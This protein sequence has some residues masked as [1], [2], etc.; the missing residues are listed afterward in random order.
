[1]AIIIILLGLGVLMAAAEIFVPGGVLGT[2]GAIAIVISIVLAF[3]RQGTAFG[4]AWL[5]A[6][7]ALTLLSIFAAAR[8]VP[9]SPLGKKILLETDQAGISSSQ[10]GLSDLLGKTGTALTDLRPAG[11]AEIESEKVDVVTSG[12]HIGRG[13]KVEVYKVDGNRV[14]VR[15]VADDNQSR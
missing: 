8:Y 1:M 11:A 3:S 7:I 5:L 9:G 14:V 2:L 10:E 4:M 13:K 15:E 6:A 12:E